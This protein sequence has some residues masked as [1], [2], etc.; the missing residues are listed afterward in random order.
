MIKQYSKI[1]AAL[2][3]VCILFA[4]TCKETDVEG[5]IKAELNKP[6][7]LAVAEK[8]VFSTDSLLLEMNGINDS[9][10]PANV[11]CVWAGNATVKLVV[12]GTGT[13]ETGL[14]LCLGQ[15]DNRF[16]QTDTVSFKQGNKSYSLILTKVN[17]YPGTD[18]VK[19]T[20]VLLL[21]KN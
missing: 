1:L 15:C 20:A 7:T 2:L 14:D 9:R 8:A 5:S 13:E 3:P 10:C 12:M 16:K 17:P 11:Q 4:S 6:I 21:K 19:K 18:E